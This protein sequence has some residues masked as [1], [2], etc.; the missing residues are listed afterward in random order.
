MGILASAF[1][2]SRRVTDLMDLQN[3]SIWPSK[4]GPCRGDHAGWLSAGPNLEPEDSMIKFDVYFD[5]V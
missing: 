3:R 2:C 4:V 5:Y 1:M